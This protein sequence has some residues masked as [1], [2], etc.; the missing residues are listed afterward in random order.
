MNNKF[1]AITTIILFLQLLFISC[2]GTDDSVDEPSDEDDGIYEMA[3]IFSNQMIIKGSTKVEGA[4]PDAKGTISL[5]TVQSTTGG[6]ALLDEGF[7]LL[8]FVNSDTDVVGAYIQ[9][10]LKETEQ[11]NTFIPAESYYDVN[12]KKNDPFAKYGKE[13]IQLKGPNNNS[14]TLSAKFSFAVLDVDFS[15]EMTAGEYCYFISVY[16]EAGNVSDEQAVCFSVL[17]W[18]GKDEILGTWSYSKKEKYPPNGDPIVTPV[19]VEKC[20]DDSFSCEAGDA[21]AFTYCET[22]NDKSYVFNADG[23]F[24]HSTNSSSTGIDFQLAYDTCEIEYS[25][26]I[27]SVTASGKWLYNSAENNIIMVEYSFTSSGVD[28]PS[29]TTIE[30]GSAQLYWLSNLSVQNEVFS[31]GQPV[32]GDLNAD[33]IIN[34][35]DSGYADFYQKQ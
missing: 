28:G 2:G 5:E 30:T 20:I 9:F 1:R 12:L 22:V 14:Q 11:S 16:D 18:G 33:G 13:G 29:T 6:I 3:E 26:T 4:T 10:A 31:Y 25:D 21:I 32:G 15:S 35:D 27:K 34:D 19:E 17:E 23:T 7:D 24:S 8:L